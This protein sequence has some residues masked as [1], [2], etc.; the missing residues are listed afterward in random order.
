VT[1]SSVSP[2]STAETQ[3]VAAAAAYDPRSVRWNFG[4]AFIDAAGW[5]LGM[6]F[7]TH[8]TI[9]PLF[10]SQLTKSDLAVGAIPAVMFLGWL[11]PGILVAG[12]IERLPRVRGRVLWVA[13]LERSMLLLMVPLC[14]WLGERHRTLLLAAFFAC[15]FVMN[16]AVGANTPAYYKLIAKTIPPSLRGRLY[17]GGGAIAGVLGVLAT[18]LAGRLLD[19]HGYPAGYAFCFL[20]AFIAQ[21]VSVLPLGVMREEVQAPEAAPPGRRHGERY[22][23]SRKTGACCSSAWRSR[24]SASTRWRRP[25]TRSTPSTGSAL[26]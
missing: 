8:T 20:G 6:S 4:A 9:L 17:G 12:H 7:I 2:S 24:C 18:F 22:A 1:G 13:M 3:P 21:T 16:T 5:G 25:S 23:S 15:W 19:I 26:R 14:F 10:I 11:L